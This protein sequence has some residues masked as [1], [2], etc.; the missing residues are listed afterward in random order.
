MTNFFSSLETFRDHLNRHGGDLCR[1]PAGHRAAARPLLDHSPEAQ[2]ML[3][4]AIGL[5]SCIAT[6]PKAPRGLADRIVAAAL[7]QDPGYKH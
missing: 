2:T 1:W 7:S 4:E 3:A 6:L 5:D